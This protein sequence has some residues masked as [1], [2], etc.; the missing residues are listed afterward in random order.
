MLILRPVDSDGT[1]TVSVWN[2]R[3]RDASKRKRKQA[4]Y[5]RA[6]IINGRY[7]YRENLQPANLHY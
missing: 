6:S 5:F 4:S 7:M 3:R 2:S 1:F